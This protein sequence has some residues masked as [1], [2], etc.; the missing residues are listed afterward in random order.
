MG[1][2]GR[3]VGGAD[4]GVAPGTEGF[5]EKVTDSKMRRGQPLE[6]PGE[7]VCS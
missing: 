2:H 5:S 3:D 6:E 1:G 7:G 4:V